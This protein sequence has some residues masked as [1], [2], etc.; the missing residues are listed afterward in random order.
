MNTAFRHPPGE[1]SVAQYVR[2]ETLVV[3]V[4]RIARIAERAA[5]ATR[6]GSAFARRLANHSLSEFVDLSPVNVVASTRA[7]SVFRN[8]HAWSMRAWSVRAMTVI[9]GSGRVRARSMGARKLGARYLGARNLGARSGR[10]CARSLQLRNGQTI[11]LHQV[12][13]PG[14]LPNLELWIRLRYWRWRG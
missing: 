14:I 11:F 2:V 12:Q 5:S 13:E 1:Q 4:R 10:G 6:S 3:D 7:W 9:V 8:V